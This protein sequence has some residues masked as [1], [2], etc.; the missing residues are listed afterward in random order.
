MQRSILHSAS[1]ILISLGF[2]GDA[3]AHHTRH[4]AQGRRRDRPR[5]T[6]STI[7]VSGAGDCAWAGWSSPEAVAKVIAMSRMFVAYDGTLTT[8]SAMAAGPR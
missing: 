3:D 4:G 5:A 7:T 1:Y 6:P 2:G 8:C